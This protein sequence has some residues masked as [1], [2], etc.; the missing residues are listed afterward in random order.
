MIDFTKKQLKDVD[1]LIANR[2]SKRCELKHDSPCFCGSTKTRGECCL[3][4]TNY[5]LSKKFLNEIIGFAKHHNFNVSKGIMPNKF[6][7]NLESSFQK[8]FNICAIP[9]CNRPCINSHVFGKALLHDHF[10]NSFCNWVV[11]DDRGVKKWSQVGIDSEIGYKIFCAECDNSFFQDID[12][13]KQEIN[14]KKN[15]LL[16][17][18]RSLAYQHQFNRTAMAIAHQIAIA[19]IPVSFERNKFLNTKVT[20]EQIDITHLVECYIRYALTK[21]DL[22]K[23][24]KILQS[25]RFD[26]IEKHLIS[27]KIFTKKGFF[28]QGIE[29]PKIDV[30]GNNV[31]LK[32]DSAIIYNITPIDDKSLSLIVFSLYDEYNPLLNQIQ[33]CNEYKCKKYFSNLIE[34]KNSPRGV[35]V[36]KNMKEN[37]KILR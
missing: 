20:H 19:Y 17:I 22:F 28:A 4:E 30:L 15:Q 37:E 26:R 34:K 3:I 32:R 8:K 21:I 10:Q 24:Y 27:R 25:D 1:I 14:N 31:E 29:N 16:H 6:I 11:I 35:L 23:V 2:V 13:L 18:F 9:G 33:D 7:K 36:N 5:W 12:N